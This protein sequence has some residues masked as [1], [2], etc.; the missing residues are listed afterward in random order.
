[1]TFIDNYREPLPDNGQA[2]DLTDAGSGNQGGPD[3]GT[4]A[5]QAGASAQGPRPGNAQV[6]PA[7]ANGAPKESNNNQTWL[8]DAPVLS[9][10]KPNAL[11]NTESRSQV[12]QPAQKP[13]LQKTAGPSHTEWLLHQAA[14]LESQS[15]PENRD[16]LDGPH[17]QARA[18]V[19]A[20][21][22]E[23]SGHDEELGALIA[24]KLSPA[25]G[26]WL[27]KTLGVQHPLDI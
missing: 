7:S 24:Q 2:P 25:E 27:A 18:Y 12:I 13:D 26:E 14:K 5:K 23:M 20:A 22:K 8:P 16:A 1:M 9:T 21:L 3:V 4:A 19:L 10:P 6:H 17:R 11:S 15:K